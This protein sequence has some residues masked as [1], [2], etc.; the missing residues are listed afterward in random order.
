MEVG[1]DNKLKEAEYRHLTAYLSTLQ[2]LK[3]KYGDIADF[4]KP[5]SNMQNQ[6]ARIDASGE[7][8]GMRSGRSSRSPS[9]T[10][11]DKKKDGRDRHEVSHR[12]NEGVRFKDDSENE[13][14]ASF[15][16]GRR[17]RTGATL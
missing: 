8:V 11:S 13:S 1:T 16:V 2:Y 15:R 6:P 5:D 10:C 14:S 12:A 9:R 3:R 7:N 17:M 4:I